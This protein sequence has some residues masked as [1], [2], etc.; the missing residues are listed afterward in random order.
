[1]CCVA[2]LTE[3]HVD[4]FSGLL[5]KLCAADLFGEAGDADGVTGV[6]LLYEEIAASFDHAV[7]LIHDGTVHD[8]NYTLLSYRDARCVCKLDKPPHHLETVITFM[9]T[10][11]VTLFD[12]FKIYFDA[13]H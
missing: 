1:M 12:G 6:E 5:M 11:Y 3:V 2:H 10:S 9:N 8:V 13:K 7:D 4:V